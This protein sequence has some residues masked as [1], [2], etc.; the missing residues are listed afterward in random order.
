MSLG[1]KIALVTGASRGIGRSIAIELA[2]R[3]ANVIVNYKKDQEGAEKTIELINEN[4]GRGF[5]YKGDVS[6]YSFCKNMIED[7]IKRFSKLDILVNNAGISKV[8]LFMDLTEEEF[9]E[10]MNVNFKGVFNCCHAV[11]EHM[12]SRK[13]GTIVNI[14]SIWGNAGASCEVIYSAS[15]G[16]VNSFTK[17]LA[18]EL[19]PSGIRVN[20]VSPGVIDTQMNKCFSIEEKEAL[21]EE[22]PMMRMGQGEDIGEVVGFLCDESSR[23]ITGQIITVDGGFL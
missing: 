20:A 15:K 8:G 1:G 17:A 13:Q 9:D 10:I 22:I 23:Y 2:K 7:I 5:L 11:V 14:S 4:G 21:I 12:I 18:K 19:A 16:A 6:S 3:G